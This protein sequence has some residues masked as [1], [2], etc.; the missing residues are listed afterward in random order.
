MG[1]TEARA[2]ASKKNGFLNAKGKIPTLFR[3]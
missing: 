3:Y 2:L 1:N